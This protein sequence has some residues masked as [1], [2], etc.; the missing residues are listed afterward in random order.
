MKT[1]IAIAY[2]PVLHKGYIDFIA[3]LK[4]EGVTMLYLIGDSILE[5]HETLDYINRKDR[6]RA[7][8]ADTI[9]PIIADTTG[10]SVQL[11]NPKAIEEIKKE[12]YTIVTPKEDIGRYIVETYFK[13]ADVVFENIFLR[14]NQDNIGEAI[15]P[16]TQKITL[17][18]FEKT[19]FAQVMSE[20][21]KSAD[22]WRQVG[23]GVVKDG[24]LVS[25]AHNEHMPEEQLPNILGDTRA[26][27]KKGVNINYVTTAHAEVGVLGELARNGIATDGCEIFLTDFPCPY[28][29]RLIVK[30]GIRKVYYLK[31]Y[32]VLGGD[33][34]LKG[35]GIELV[36][37]TL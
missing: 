13:D 37:V 31:G 20:A 34:F 19:V 12:G 29:A 5:A 14:W 35:E 1:R 10:L 2:I 6:L 26:L 16:D 8:P 21:E 9:G 32:A 22:W 33:E 3:K 15:E 30:A 24:K 23:A 4:N 28:C 25:V 11:L 7:I 17:S 36:R 27:F 18:D